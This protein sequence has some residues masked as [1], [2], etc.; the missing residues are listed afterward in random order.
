MRCRHGLLGMLLLLAATAPAEAAGR[1]AKAHALARDRSAAQSALDRASDPPTGRELTPALAQLSARYGALSAAGQ[2]D[3]DRLLARP[4][5]GGA[6]P[7]QQGWTV[8]EH[9]PYCTANFCLH[10]VTTTEDAPDLLDSDA[11]GVPDYV[12]TMGAHF[13]TSRARENGDLGWRAPVSDGA[14]G[15]DGRVDVY[16]VELAGTGTLGYAATDPGQPDP[17]AKFAYVVM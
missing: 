8:P 11:D 10:W 9:A 2:R 4:A 12:E 3:A 16:L 1:D 14:L 6:D 7:E 5:D 17:H 15:G 13:E